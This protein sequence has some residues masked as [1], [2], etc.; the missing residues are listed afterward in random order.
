MAVRVRLAV[1]L[2]RGAGY[3]EEFSHLYDDFFTRRKKSSG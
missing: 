3:P 1:L 2:M